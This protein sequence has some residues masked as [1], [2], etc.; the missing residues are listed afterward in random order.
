M[1]LYSLDQ[2]SDGNISVLVFGCAALDITASTSLRSP[3]STS[4][5][6]VRFSSGG[7]GRNM[8]E[9]AHR[10]LSTSTSDKGSR[11]TVGL[12]APLQDDAAG[13]LL[14]MQLKSSG[15]TDYFIFPSTSEASSPTAVLQLDATTNDLVSGVVDMSLVEESLTPS[16][17]RVALSAAF[18]ED[19]KLISPRVVGFDANMTPAAMAELLRWRQSLSQD[20]RILLFEPTSVAKCARLI[21]ALKSMTDGSSRPLVD[22]IT[23]NLIELEAMVTRAVEVGLVQEV[24][25][26]TLSSTV[27]NR[28]EVLCTALS[29]WINQFLVT[30]GSQGVMSVAKSEGDKLSMERHPAIIFDATTSLVN[31]TGAGDTFAG[32][33]LA[34]LSEPRGA[35]REEDWPDTKRWIINLAQQGA[36]M[37]L[38]SEEAVS[39]QV[40]TLAKLLPW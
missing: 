32:V 14:K 10:V 28:L 39:K 1:K 7:V 5:G 16:A 2:Q 15:M 24:P 37:T 34:C 27:E 9:A 3:N 33:M 30:M 21:D 8:A 38:Q 23:P 31:S 12:V 19:P 22:Y 18:R 35:R 6:T 40:G 20:D 17:I 25:S 11:P 26:L 4:P 36:W 29:P 13:H